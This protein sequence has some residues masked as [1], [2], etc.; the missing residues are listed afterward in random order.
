MSKVAR[1]FRHRQEDQSISGP[2]LS[3]IYPIAIGYLDTDATTPIYKE[4]YNISIQVC[5]DY[6][7]WDARSDPSPHAVSLCRIGMI[8]FILGGTYMQ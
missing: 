1:T 3:E 7:V 4:L 6:K 2:R 8:R 5:F